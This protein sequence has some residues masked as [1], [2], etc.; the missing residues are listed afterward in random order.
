MCGCSPVVFAC[1]YASVC[2]SHSLCFEREERLVF[3]QHERLRLVK[4][5]NL[6]G[7]SA[8]MTCWIAVLV[9]APTPP[10]NYLTIL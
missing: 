8:A 4:P 5:S 3:I 6:I 9:Y 10:E 2:L 1:V 7:L